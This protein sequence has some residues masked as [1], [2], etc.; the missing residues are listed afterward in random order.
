MTAPLTAITPE[1]A[2]RRVAAGEAVMIDIRDRDEWARRHIDGA[3]SHPL[4]ELQSA[5]FAPSRDVIFLCRSGNRTAMNRDRLSALVDGAAMMLDG[6]IDAWQKAGLPVEINPKAP[7]EL[8]RQVQIAAGMLV[9]VGVILGSTVAP[10]FYG[11]AA[12]VGA[13]LTFAGLTGFCGMAKLLAIMP[14]NRR[15]A[16]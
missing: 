10:L 1:E 13:G 3:L 4:S 15:A 11:V 9:L 5:R 8:M 14:W 6:G 2:H 7:L 16:A 12:F